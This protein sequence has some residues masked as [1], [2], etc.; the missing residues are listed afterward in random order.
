MITLLALYLSFSLSFGGA[1]PPALSVSL[2]PWL[3]YTSH[4]K[5]VWP[6]GN[7]SMGLTLPGLVWVDSDARSWPGWFQKLER[8][9]WNHA[10]QIQFLS[11]PGMM[12][13]YVIGLGAPFEDY[14]W[15]SGP[16][17]L[18]PAPAPEAPP[19]WIP[20]CPL[21]TFDGS[22]VALWRCGPMP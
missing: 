3:L 2:D 15:A 11:A 5:I 13:A 21:L 1:Q 4:G 18:P 22:G 12:T 6:G 7:R 10:R 16:Q 14:F 9:E 20:R 8:H 19:A 17:W